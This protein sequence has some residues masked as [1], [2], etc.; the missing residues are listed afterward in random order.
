MLM[1][2]A[3]SASSTTAKTRKTIALTIYNTTIDSPS[4]EME[5]SEEHAAVTLTTDD[6][7]YVDAATFAA[8]ARRQAAL[9][10]VS[11]VDRSSAAGTNVNTGPVWA[12][13]V[14]CVS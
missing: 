5:K 7:E 10:V 8:Q 11:R 14:A 3:S 12:R 2:S 13:D 6:K 1:L 4:E 9:P